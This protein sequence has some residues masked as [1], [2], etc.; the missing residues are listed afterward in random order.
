MRNIKITN[1]EKNLLLILLGIVFV[2]VSYYFGYQTLKEETENLKKQNVALES[3][4]EA[5]ENIEASNDQYVEDTDKIQKTMVGQV[6]L[7]R[8]INCGMSRRQGNG[9]KPFLWETATWV[10]WCTEMACMN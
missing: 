3:Q 10:P 1:R 2:A 4:I 7:W 9:W 5:L 6:R 8:T